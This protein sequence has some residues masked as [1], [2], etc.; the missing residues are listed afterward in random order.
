MYEIYGLHRNYDNNDNTLYILL[1]VIID[2]EGNYD[3]EKG[4]LVLKSD[5]EFFKDYSIVYSPE[6]VREFKL[7]NGWV[8]GYGTE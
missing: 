8:Y 7:A 4:I 5:E 3:K 2:P 1:W 6:E